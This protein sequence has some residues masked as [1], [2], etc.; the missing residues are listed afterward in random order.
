[1]LLL[2]APLRR[3]TGATFVFNSCSLLRRGRVATP[4]F[5]VHV[6]A[7]GMRATAIPP[8][9]A[10]LASCVRQ[11]STVA[12]STWWRASR[13][14]RSWRQKR[15]APSSEPLRS[16]KASKSRVTS[17]RRRQPKVIEGKTLKSVRGKQQQKRLSAHQR[18]AKKYNK[19]VEAIAR[20]W[21]EQQQSASK[22]S[23]KSLAPR[24]K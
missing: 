9:G 3:L 5:S 18:Q 17:T 11:R 15:T 22:S 7:F 10:S 16:K 14:V 2:S 13:S 23:E 8:F 20:L 19:R 12:R 1:M 4:H 6:G 24:R 21:K